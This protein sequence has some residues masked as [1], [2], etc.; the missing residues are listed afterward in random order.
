MMAIVAIQTWSTNEMIVLHRTNISKALI[1]AQRKHSWRAIK[2]TTIMA[3]TVMIAHRWRI[4]AQN[5]IYMVISYRNATNQMQML[6]IRMVI[7]DLVQMYHRFHTLILMNSIMHRQEMVRHQ[8][9]ITFLKSDFSMLMMGKF[10]AVYPRM[11]PPGTS[12]P[13]SVPN[14]Q[15]HHNNHQ[16]HGVSI[17]MWWKHSNLHIFWV[18]IANVFHSVFADLLVAST[19][20]SRCSS[21]A[22]AAS[23]IAAKSISFT[24]HKRS[25][26]SLTVTSICWI[27]LPNGSDQ[28][29]SITFIRNQMHPNHLMPSLLTICDLM[30]NQLFLSLLKQNKHTKISTSLK[31]SAS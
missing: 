20:T 9:I 19:N 7:M 25:F 22:I 26:K 5:R 13:S 28:T 23:S 12:R 10:L 24:K 14:A 30:I 17:S 8:I 27:K 6:K 21:T 15:Y 1:L 3:V 16:M 4:M 18:L 2:S 31:A 11:T 29:I